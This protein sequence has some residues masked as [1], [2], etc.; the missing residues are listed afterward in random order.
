MKKNSDI[1]KVRKRVGQLFMVGFPGAELD[2]ATTRLI[3]EYHIGGIILFKRNISDHAQIKELCDQMQ[4]L[5]QEAGNPRPLLIA[6]DQEGGEVSRLNGGVFDLPPAMAFGAARD[7]DLNYR[8]SL[9]LASRLR[10][11]GINI[12]LAPVLDLGRIGGNPHLTTRVYSDSQLLTA[13]MGKLF[14]RGHHE[15]GIAACA[16]HFPGLGEADI[17]THLDLAKAKLSMDD[18]LRHECIPFSEAIENS[19]DLIMTNHCWYNNIEPKPLPTTLSKRLVTDMLRD[20]LGFRKVV[21]SDDL[22]MGAISKRW[23]IAEAAALAVEA[24]VNMLLICHHPQQQA[25][26]IEHLCKLYLEDE[27]FADKVE[28]SYRLICRL[29]DELLERAARNNRLQM[30]SPYEHNFKELV[31]KF[32]TGVKNV[33]QHLPLEPAQLDKVIILLPE[34]LYATG[35]LARLGSPFV[36][37]LASRCSQVEIILYGKEIP[38]SW[39]QFSQHY[40]EGSLCIIVSVNSHLYQPEHELLEEIALR[41]PDTIL[42]SAGEPYDIS[43]YLTIPTAVAC[44][45][46]NR[47][48]QSYMIEALCGELKM[49]GILPVKI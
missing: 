20:Q 15:A 37:A 35:E 19:V 44:Y 10:E 39:E 2:S 41:I 12:N 25:P 13:D 49:E 8:W 26:A 33:R 4:Q 17:D 16:K 30:S 43:Q 6:V 9:M 14:I 18:L 7:F 46:F 42:I 29:K 34:R 22:S 47:R 38:F 1:Y 28:D 11:L 45:T 5:N 27:G 48:Y 23:S 31:S 24:G 21:I 3:R 36:Q 32:L 40:I